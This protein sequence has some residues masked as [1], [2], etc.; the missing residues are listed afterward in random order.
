MLWVQVDL[1]DLVGALKTQMGLASFPSYLNP[2]NA[3]ADAM[4]DIICKHR[5]FR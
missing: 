1:A 5:H 2:K 3:D 4:Y